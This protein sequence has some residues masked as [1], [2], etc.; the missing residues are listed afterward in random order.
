M[1]VEKIPL[2]VLEAVRQ[3]LGADSVDD[4]TFDEKIAK[5]SPKKLMIEWSGWHLGDGSWGG[6]IIA[7][8][9]QLKELEKEEE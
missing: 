2:P 3:R 1:D 6:N 8:Y 5:M 4:I 7:M 9:E